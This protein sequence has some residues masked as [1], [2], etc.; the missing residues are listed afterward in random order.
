MDIF[1]AEKL[2]YKL[3]Q[4]CPIKTGALKASI[5]RPQLNANEWVITIGNEDAA[6]NG[7][8]TIQYAATTNFAAQL[9]V[10]AKG[11]R[12]NPS[13]PEF[14]VIANPNYHWVNKAVKEWITE[15]KLLLDIKSED[16]N[17]DGTG[18][19]IT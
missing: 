15:N 10:F 13:I 19:D 4:K 16:D 5:S 6:I 17:D 9:K 14:T 12:K 7:T 3:R 11:K 18:V 8:P 1:L 2:A